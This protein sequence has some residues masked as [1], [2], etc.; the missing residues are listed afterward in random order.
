MPKKYFGTD[1]IR[2][3]VGNEIINAEFM[4]R[5]GWAFGRVLSTKRAMNTVKVLI[6]R[7][8]RNS[9]TMIESALQAGLTAAGVNVFLLGILPTPAIAHLTHSLRADAGIVISASH[10]LYQDNGIKFFDYQGMK[11]ADEIELAIET[12]LEKPM[13]TVNAEKLGCVSQLIDAGGRYIEFCK[14]LFP[15]ALTLKNVKLVVDCANGAVFDVAPKIFHELG[16]KVIA[17][18]HSPDGFNI[19]RECGATHVQQLQQTVL[20]EKADLGIALDGDGD[21]LIMVDAKGETVDGDE[22]LCILAKDK[23]K[24]ITEQTGVVGTVMSNLGLEQ[25]LTQSGIHFQRAKVGDRYVLE[26]LLQQGWSLGGESSGHIVDLDHTTTGDGLI[27]ALQILRIMQISKAPLHQLK[28]IMIKRPQVLINVPIQREKQEQDILKFPKIC[29]AIQLAEQELA[30]QGR[31][32]LRPSGTEPLI[33]VM[34]EGNNASIVQAMAL[35]L[36]AMVE[37]EMT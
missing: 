37:Q 11:L 5:L 3:Q 7:D 33:R 32:L 20:T 28:K 25:A 6:G 36:A 12:Q 14:S 1:G 24:T 21:R 26:T 31:V 4:L 35:R 34:V 2:G 13:R 17:I 23:I 27:T 10:N 22:T 19:N 9:G 18:N 30:D 16:A 15:S 8:T 29:E